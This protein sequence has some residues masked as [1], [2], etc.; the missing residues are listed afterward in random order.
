MSRKY[1][2]NVAEGVY[3]LSC[4]AV[5]WVNVFDRKEY[6]Q[7]VLDS[8]RFCIKNK[9]LNLHAYIIMSNHI[10]LI[11]SAA[12]GYVLSHII[13]DFKKFTSQR[14]LSLIER[15]ETESRR[16]WMLTIFA[17]AGEH[18]SSN[19]KYQLWRHDNHYIE[20]DSNEIIE[21]KLDYLHNNPIE[22]GYVYEAEHYVFSSAAQY[23]GIPGDVELVFLD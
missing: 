1:R 22:A 3:F 9:G 17:R 13:R 5:G 8:L 11:V 20:L 19:E 15:D 14:I 7:I 4:A 6:K 10:H 21:Q 23:A 16:R 2:A 18:N 12:Q